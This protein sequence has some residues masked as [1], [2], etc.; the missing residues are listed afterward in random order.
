MAITINGT[1]INFGTYSLD[2]S[3]NG[4]STSGSITAIGGFVS[5]S[6]PPA[7]GT[8]SGYSS[9][10]YN[11]PVASNTNRIDK[12]PFSTPFTTATDVGDLS[13]ARINYSYPTSVVNGTTANLFALVTTTCSSSTGAVDGIALPTAPMT[14]GQ[15]TVPQSS[16]TYYMMRET[17]GAS[18]PFC[19][20]CRSPSRIWTAGERIR[21][22]YIIGNIG[23]A[24]Y[25]NPTDTFFIGI[26]A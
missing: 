6:L 24:N 17:S 7:I 13:Q 19:S 9:G 14:V 10:G 12:F 11:P 8:I 21:V 18:I 3:A 16:N 5:S 23:N 4:V 26:A 20:L 25:Y 22:A 1:S 15:A 2:L